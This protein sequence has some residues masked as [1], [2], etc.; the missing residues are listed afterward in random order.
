MLWQGDNLATMAAMDKASRAERDA[1]VGGGGQR[2]DIS[3]RAGDPGGENPRNR[4]AKPRRNF[5]PTVKPVDLMRWLVRLVT[6]PGGTV[7]DPFA[8]SGSTLIAAV[9]E[10]FEVIGCER[11]GDYVELAIERLGQPLQVAML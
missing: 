4:G 2:R 6:P 5:H 1:G 9:L 10:G 7:L 11:D 3:R 8:G